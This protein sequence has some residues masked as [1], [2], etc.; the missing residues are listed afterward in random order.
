[1]ST[2]IFGRRPDDFGRRQAPMPMMSRLLIMA[3]MAAIPIASLM[4]KGCQS[5][6]F[7]RHQ[8]V[9]I[10]PEQEKEL[11]LQA[12]KEVLAQERVVRRGPLVDV[13]REIAS[14]LTSA[15]K[16]E[17]FLHQTQLPEQPMEW[18]VEVVESDQQNAFCLPG[19]KIVVYTGILPIAQ[20]DAGLAVVMGHEI[21]HALAHHGAERMA[22]QQMAQIGVMAAGGALGDMDPGKRNQILSMINAGAKFGIMAYGRGHETEADHMGLLLMAAAGYDPRESVTFWER[23]Q[24]FSGGKSPPEFLSTH[25]SHETRVRDLQ[26]WLPEAMPLYEASPHKQK[27]EPLPGVNFGGAEWRPRQDPLQLTSSWSRSAQRP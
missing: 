24:K 16:Y 1:M 27:P 5:G 4:L 12:F 15:A 2:D 10:N 3:L 8:V 18:A 20:T 6:P 19:G 22:Q 11:G 25:P 14:R 21:S 26:S 13:I 7:G 17:G 9:A 23:M